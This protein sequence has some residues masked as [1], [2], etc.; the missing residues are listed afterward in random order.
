M[1]EPSGL[2]GTSP[3]DEA[4]DT[5]QNDSEMGKFRTV[6]DEIAFND[7]LKETLSNLKTMPIT[8]EKVWNQLLDLNSQNMEMQGNQGMIAGKQ[9]LQRLR[10]KKQKEKLEF[11]QGLDYMI[12]A[13]G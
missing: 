4:Y 2:S 9:A 1:R 6:E 8:K 3:E 12:K 13:T 7:Q 11:E 5:I 10:A